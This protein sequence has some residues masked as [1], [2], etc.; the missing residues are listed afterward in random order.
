MLI[1]FDLDG[2][3]LDVSG[4]FYKIYSDILGERD[5][6]TLPKKRYWQLKKERT[7][8][9]Q[10]ILQTCPQEFVE[11]YIKKRLEV[12]ENFEYLKHDKIILGAE[13][14]LEELMINHQLILVTLRNNSK[15]LFQEL[16]F[17]DLKKYFTTILSL[18]NNHGDWR[19][20][21]KLIQESGTLT[22]QNSMIVGDTEADIIAGKNL[23][24]KTCA[25]LSGIRTKEL[26]EKVSPDVLIE[27]INSLREAIRKIQT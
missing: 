1:Y 7:P 2:P 13:K 14:V 10:I 5:L 20:K 24:I 16:E 18:D 19:I 12:I 17:F 26:L 23:G 11:H 22:D 4:K 3:V 25:V 9:P 27:D 21:V 8:I 6:P 15:T